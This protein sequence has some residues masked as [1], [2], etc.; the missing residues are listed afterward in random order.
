MSV[1][2]RHGPAV[3]LLYLLRALAWYARHLGPARADVV[4]CYH[5]VPGREK[6]RFRR[7]MHFLAR[8]GRRVHVTFD[9]AYANILTNALPVLEEYGVPATVF[10]VPGSLGRFPG[11]I[12]QPGHPDRHERIVSFDE[13]VHLAEHP[14]IRIGSHTFSHPR[15]PGLPSSILASELRDSKRILERFLDY[16]VDALALPHGAFDREVLRAAREAGY[17]QVFTLEPRIVTDDHLDDF[18]VGRFSMT[19]DTW[20][21]EFRLTCAGAYAWL[22]SWRRLVAGWRHGVRHHAKLEV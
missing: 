14:L 1:Y 18:L 11:W 4:L 22:E 2:A 16:P 13:L 7:Q 10:V 8:R 12:D 9:D 20:L 15:L 17:R 21:L 19:P 6:L 3:R 5:G